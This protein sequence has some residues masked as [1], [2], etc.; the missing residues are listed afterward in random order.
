MVGLGEILARKILQ[1]TNW[2]AWGIPGETTW[3]RGTVAFELRKFRCFVV[4][5]NDGE[6]RSFLEGSLVGGLEHLW[7]NHGKTYYGN[8]Y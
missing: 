4:E 3:D 8:V 5:K 2:R 1:R 7:E 6:N